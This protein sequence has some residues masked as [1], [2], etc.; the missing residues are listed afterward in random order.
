MPQDQTKNDFALFVVCWKM[1][2]LG[3]RPKEIFKMFDVDEFGSL[4]THEFINGIQNTL[5]LWLS[6]DECTSL[7]AFLD[8]D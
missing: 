4:K 6:E 5:N 3:K 1:A 7:I 8:E 2:K